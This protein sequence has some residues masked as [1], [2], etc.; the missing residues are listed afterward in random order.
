MTTQLFRKVI[1][2][3]KYIFY[4]HID[5]QTSIKQLKIEIQFIKIII[6]L[7]IE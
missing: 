1:I 2:E 5:D 4:L 7:F 6:F 3:H